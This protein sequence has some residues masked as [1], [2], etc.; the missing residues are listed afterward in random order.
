M[1]HY[2]RFAILMIAASAIL[3]MLATMPPRVP[4]P[5]YVVTET[6]CV[7]RPTNECDVSVMSENG[8]Q[9][10]VTVYFGVAGYISV[11]TE[12]ATPGKER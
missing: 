8:D 6:P 3:V 11:A 4:D 1:G 2:I 10:N 7:V 5:A 12:T 9:S